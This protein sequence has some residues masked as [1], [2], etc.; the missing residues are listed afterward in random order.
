MQSIETALKKLE[1]SRFRASFH[2]DAKDIDYINEKGL[3][4]VR[5]HAEDFVRTKLAP[6][7]PLNDGKQTPTH[8]HPAFRAM[9]ATA[10]CCRGCLNKWYKVPKNR[11]LTPAQQEKI[12]NLI[13]AWIEKQLISQPPA[14]H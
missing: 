6:A 10:C 1:K 12:V 4:T 11:A 2:L 7:E 9:H 5:R 14:G 3:E 8:G 13:M